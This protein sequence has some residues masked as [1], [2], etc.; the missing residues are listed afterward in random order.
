MVISEIKHVKNVYE[1]IGDHFS[2]T[3]AYQWK[4]VQEFTNSLRDTDVVLDIG[5]GNGRNLKKNY[6]GIDNCDVFLKQCEEKGFRTVKADMTKIPLSTGCA[7]AIISI[8]SFHHLSTHERRVQALKEM[9]R[10]LK[11][12]G[13][14]L[15][16]VWSK[17]QPKKTRRTFKY[18]DNIVPWN[19]GGKIYNRYYYIF[20][21]KELT[22]LLLQTRFIIQS[23]CFECGNEVVV[24][25]I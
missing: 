23:V 6:I 21:L 2:E 12:G 19:K 7:D 17:H 3:R 13:K 4:W 22:D 5:C 24:C 11:P 14:L 25:S 18:G 20:Y 9:R 1:E 8:A 15:L 16:S 10:L